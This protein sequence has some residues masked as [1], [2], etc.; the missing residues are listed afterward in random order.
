MSLHPEITK[1]NR[2]NL[3]YARMGEPTWN[4]DV[5][6][7][8]KELINTIH[9][10]HRLHPVIST[11]MPKKNSFLDDFLKMW[12]NIKNNLLDGEAGLQ[13]SINSTDEYQRQEMF[14][15]NALTLDQIGELVLGL[16]KPK[17]RKI[18]LNFALNDTY[19]VDPYKLLSNFSTDDYLV[20]ITPMHVTNACLTND[21][22]TSGGYDGYYPYQ[23]A[24]KKLK[25]VGYDVIVFV[26]S[27]EE[28]ESRIT[29][30]NAVLSDKPTDL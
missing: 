13:L 7:A 14:S 28:D 21:L 19:E 16:P 18:T 9:K 10:T 11:M 2:L 23:E 25:D 3:H 30:G 12:M 1:T 15:G 22:K 26:P 20:K 5:I 4:F 29:C 6:S 17:G 8:T 27:K 24:E